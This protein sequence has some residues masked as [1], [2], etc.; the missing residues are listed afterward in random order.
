MVRYWEGYVEQVVGIDN[1]N[2]FTDKDVLYNYQ[3][4]SIRFE[5]A[6]SDGD[7]IKFSGYKKYLVMAQVEDADSINAFGLRENLLEIA[8][9]KIS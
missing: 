3:A 6:L 7:I 5:N 8:L 2:D 4:D 1:M 9:L